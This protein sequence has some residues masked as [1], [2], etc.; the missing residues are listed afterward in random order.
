MSSVNFHQVVPSWREIQE[1]DT[2]KDKVHESVYRIYYIMQEVKGMLARG[3]SNETILKVIDMLDT[4]PNLQYM[5]ETT[6]SEDEP[7]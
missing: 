6:T 4:G 7:E 5:T 3:D 1:M 2:V